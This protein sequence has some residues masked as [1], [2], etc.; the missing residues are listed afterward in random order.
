MTEHHFPLAAV[1]GADSLKLA[2]CL[3]A[4]D[5]AIGGEGEVMFGHGS[6]PWR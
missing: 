4:I 3:A 5:P 6:D 2:L 1:V